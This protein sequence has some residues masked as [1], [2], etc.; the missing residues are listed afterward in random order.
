[1]RAPRWLLGAVVVA[2]FAGI[3]LGVWLYGVLA[4]GAAPV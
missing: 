1:M 2:A 3:A 4:G